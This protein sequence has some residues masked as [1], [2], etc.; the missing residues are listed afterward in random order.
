MLELAKL[1]QQLNYQFQDNQ[2]LLQALTHRSFSAKNN[3]RLEFLGDAILSYVIAQILYRRYEGAHEG[4]LSRY[5]SNIVRGESLATIAKQL[6]LGNYLYLGIGEL[7]SGGHQRNSILADTVE[8]IIGAIYLDSNIEQ[9][10]TVIEHVFAQ[11]IVSVQAQGNLKD[12]KTQLQEFLQQ[13]Q[14]QLPIYEVLDITGKQHDQCFIV[15][16]RV[17]ETS[18]AST[19]KGSSRRKAEQAAAAALLTQLQQEKAE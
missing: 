3:E 6:D 2:L 4:E 8:A 19:G 17:P 18:L 13:H 11:A 14:Y 5:R 15:C 10:T 12:P 7:K 16:C 9:V 1:C